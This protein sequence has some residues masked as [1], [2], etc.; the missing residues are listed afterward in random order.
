MPIASI[1]MERGSNY[2]H[3]VGVLSLKLMSPTVKLCVTCEKITLHIPLP[4]DF[5]DGEDFVEFC[6]CDLENLEFLAV[7]DMNSLSCVC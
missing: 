1:F 4:F 2:G 6:T 7:C 3:L 5:H